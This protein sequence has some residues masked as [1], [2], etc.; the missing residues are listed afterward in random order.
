MVP[1]ALGSVMPNLRAG[2]ECGRTCPSYPE[3]ISKARPV[4]TATRPPG[5]ISIGSAAADA[6]SIPAAPADM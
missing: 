3:G 5:G 4:G 1:G 2:P 6:R